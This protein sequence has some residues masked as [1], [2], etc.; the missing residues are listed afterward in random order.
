MKFKV[1]AFGIL[2]FQSAFAGVLVNI[3]AEDRMFHV[4]PEAFESDEACEAM[5]SDPK[6]FIDKIVRVRQ[7][8]D[9]SVS[10]QGEKGGCDVFT[11]YLAGFPLEVKELWP[12]VVEGLKKT[13]MSATGV[14][15]CVNP[16][17]GHRQLVG[18]E[19][20]QPYSKVS[21]SLWEFDTRDSFSPKCLTK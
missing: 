16:R 19:I 14:I 17:A 11:T 6:I 15:F 13:G 8:G 18:V 12:K 4:Y 7:N 9:L 5:K 3:T 21:T 2:A 20:M 1:F 10:I